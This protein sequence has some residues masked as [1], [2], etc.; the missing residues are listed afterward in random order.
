MTASSF[1]SWTPRPK[2]PVDLSTSGNQSMSLIGTGGW[3]TCPGPAANR[4]NPSSSASPTS[5]TRNT[6]PSEYCRVAPSPVTNQTVFWSRWLTGLLVK[7]R[8]GSPS[9]SGR[10]IFSVLWYAMKCRIRA[11]LAE[12]P[13]SAAAAASAGYEVPETDKAA[14]VC[15]S[16]WFGL[17]LPSVRVLGDRLARLLHRL[18][19]GLG[20]AGRLLR[21]VEPIPALV[22]HLP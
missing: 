1:T 5:A 4:L 8:S 18:R 14:A 12:R 15:C 3:N 10:P 2:C 6:L 22:V 16:G 17:L 13:R 20:G 21:P 11:S 19:L 9:C 7:S